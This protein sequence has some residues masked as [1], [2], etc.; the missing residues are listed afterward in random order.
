MQLYVD[1]VSKYTVNAGQMNTSYPLTSGAHRLTVTGTDAAG[2]TSKAT[3][4]VT[5]Q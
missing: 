4:T 1:G 2:V 5:V 3:I